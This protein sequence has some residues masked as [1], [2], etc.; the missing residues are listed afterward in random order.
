MQHSQWYEKC[1]YQ[2]VRDKLRPWLLWVH[3]TTASDVAFVPRHICLLI[4]RP[5]EA[6]IEIAFNYLNFIVILIS[7]RTYFQCCLLCFGGK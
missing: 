6:D 1:T 7:L 4:Y 5:N 3:S 2:E